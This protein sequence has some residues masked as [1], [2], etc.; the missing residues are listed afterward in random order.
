MK[1]NIYFFLL[2]ILIITLTQFL[3]ELPWWSFLTISLLMGFIYTFKNWEIRPFTIGFISGFL[4]WLIISLVFHFRFNGSLIAKITP[5]F[6]INT[7]LFFIITGFIGGLLNG[8]ACYTG[9]NVLIIEEVLE[10]D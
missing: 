7:T 10:L 3:I 1:N 2:N 9:Y 6:Y 4:N 5:I 8:L